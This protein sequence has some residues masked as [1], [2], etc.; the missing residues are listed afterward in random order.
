L[1]GNILEIEL[2]IPIIS[3]ILA[4]IAI[5]ATLV[6][7]FYNALQTTKAMWSQSIINLRESYAHEDMLIGMKEIPKW[8]SKFRTTQIAI[9]NFINHRN[10]KTY[11]EYKI[12]KYRRKLTHYLFTIYCLK[13]QKI[14][15][16]EFVKMMIEEDTIKFFNKWVAPLEDAII[17]KE[18]IKAK[19]YRLMVDYYSNLK[20]DNTKNRAN[21]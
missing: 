3:I 12:D 10:H 11:S 21:A 18:D 15:N 5:V 17:S 8:Y 1:G 2:I 14:V 16:N 19:E 13:K 20:Y 4:I 6:N 7:G 9:N